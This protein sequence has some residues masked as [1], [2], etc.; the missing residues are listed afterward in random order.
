[1]QRKITPK[2]LVSYLGCGLFCLFVCVLA[3]WNRTLLLEPVTAFLRGEGGFTEMKSTVQSNYVGDRLRGKFELI[4]LNGGYARL[5]GRSLYN[6]TQRMTN[7]MLTSTT[8]VQRDTTAFSDN[9]GRFCHYLQEN[10]T[11]F[12]FVMTPHKLPLEDNL[13]PVGV[14]DKTNA[15]A[16]QV[17]AELRE[18]GVP[19]LDLRPEM[20][21]TKELVEKYYYRTDHHWNVEGSLYA[22]QRIMETLKDFYPETKTNFIDSSLW[23][24]TVI[25][26]WWLGSHGQ[27]VGALFGG[28]EDL[29]YYLPAFPTDMTRYSLGLWTCRGDFYQACMRDYMLENRDYMHLDNYMRY[30]GMGW[31]LTLH[32]NPRAENRMHLMMIGDSYTLP[33]EC[34]LSTE[35]TAIDM[36]DPRQYTYMRVVDYATLNAPD[37]VILMTYPGVLTSSYYDDYIDFGQGGQLQVEKETTVEQLIS[38]GTDGQHHYEVLPVRMEAGK[39]YVLTLDRVRVNAGDPAG[40]NVMVYR[41]EDQIDLTIFNIEYGNEFGYRWG[42]QLPED[43]TGEDFE[44][45]FYA[46]V[47]G[48]T[49]G[50]ELAYEGI[51]LQE[52]VIRR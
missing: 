8:P 30:L 1:M 18:K 49:E 20:S 17:L 26:D 46:G 7:G 37:M 13:L 27:R 12:L 48:G 24:K 45:R 21:R 19:T 22:F 39:S 10:G 47:D 4:T 42:F 5:E 34:F 40:A 41:G 6:G 3:F 51:R 44:L 14:T 31:S 11:P 28:V 43:P 50:M 52:C 23:E 32:R 9:V 15:V 2:R 36:M 25:P 29:D 33:V 38:S 16:D 35:L